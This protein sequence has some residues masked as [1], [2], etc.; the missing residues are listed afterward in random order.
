MKN[1]HIGGEYYY[2]PVL[3]L[4]KKKV[5]FDEYVRM[6]FSD[7]FYSYTGGGYFSISS[8][9]KNIEFQSK[10]KVLL[11]SYI[12]PTVLIPFQKQKISYR[13]YKISEHLKVDINDLQ[14][15]ITPDIKAIF[16]IN[17]FGFPQDEEVRIFLKELKEKGIIIIE[18]MVHSFF[19]RSEVTGNYAFNS[20][21]KFMPVDG[22]VIISEKEFSNDYA[23]SFNKYFFYQLAGRYAKYFIFNLGLKNDNLFLNFFKKAEKLYYTSETFGFNAYN[24][25]IFSKIDIAQLREKRT[26][27]FTMLLNNLK[28]Y[29]LFHCLPNNVT[30][31]SFP[32]IIDK[33][34]KIRSELAKKKIFC[35]V[36]WK[37]PAEINRKEFEESWY[38]SEK[39]LSIPVNEKINDVEL[40]YLLRN[41]EDNLE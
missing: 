15:K 26:F 7:R 24:N 37:L 20:L 8:I 21:R 16:F 4:K 11:P 6:N 36:H 10:D 33:R 32:I 22:S 27:T 13:F 41:F 12:C 1:Y 40:K 2:S 30:P 29:S 9:L 35:P 38:L 17:Y 18:D 39:I 34:D 28:D 31:L 14:N 25:Y 3:I 23:A 19:S 5:F